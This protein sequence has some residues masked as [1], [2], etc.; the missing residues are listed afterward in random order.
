MDDTKSLVRI[1]DLAG[2]LAIDQPLVT[3]EV[4]EREAALLAVHQHESALKGV[5]EAGHTVVAGVLGIRVKS[6]DVGIR[7]G[8]ETTLA[9]EDETDVA[10]RTA[11]Q[12]KDLVVIMLAGMEAERHFLGE[13]TDGS[14]GDLLEATNQ[15]LA[16]VGAGMEPAAPAMSHRAF[17]A[18]SSLPHPNWMVDQIAK[19][20]DERM[21]QSRERSAELVTAHADQI[22]SFARLLVGAPSRRLSDDKLDDAMASIGIELPAPAAPIGGMRRTRRRRRA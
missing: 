4:T 9:L 22:L 19:A 1:G 11:T 6:A 20:V 2:S 12:M 13:P 17:G 7:H 10:F 16:I 3:V 14:S 5:H 8:G 21:K 18:Y 15:C